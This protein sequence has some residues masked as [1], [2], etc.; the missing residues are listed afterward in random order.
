[1]TF[2]RWGP[3]FK[4]HRRLFQNAFSQS[5]IKAFR[6]VQ[7][8]ES[9]KAVRSLVKNPDSWNETTLL[10]ATS[11]IFSISY[12][13]EIESKDSKYCHMSQAASRATAD[14]GIAGTTLVDAFPLARFL[15]NWMNP[16]AALRHARASRAAIRAIHDVPW[17]ANM[18]NIESGTARPSFMKTHWE[19]LVESVRTGKALDMTEADIK[20]ATG[21]ICIAGGNSTW[22]LVLSCMLFLTKYPAVQKKMQ[23]EIDRVLHSEGRARLPAFDDRKRL[24]CI[25]DFIMETMRCLPLNPLII[26][27]KSLEDDVYKGMLIP[28][29]TTVFANATAM[30][31]SPETYARPD[32]FDPERYSRGEPVPHGNFGYGRRKCP[33]NWLALAS[34]YMFLATFLAVFEL[35]QIVDEEGKPK[36]PEPGVT[37][38]I[39]G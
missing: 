8:H 1:M 37:V 9:R 39:G 11:I 25:D 20:G 21:A 32:M 14:G 6:P 13:Q 3:R 38:G 18:K 7:L 28:A 24:S 23:D 33:G 19:K 2:L 5:N 12:G 26:P 29:G 10:W 34:V 36:V 30:A 35:E 31:T 27:H 22:A 15:P 4:L 17:A 16:S